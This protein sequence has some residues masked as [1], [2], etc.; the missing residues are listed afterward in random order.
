MRTPR[1]CD[2]VSLHL[3]AQSVSRELGAAKLVGSTLYVRG[4]LQ[5][6]T[7]EREE[8]HKKV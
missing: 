6:D 3:L 8:L 7:P 2:G 5:N 4:S 1:S